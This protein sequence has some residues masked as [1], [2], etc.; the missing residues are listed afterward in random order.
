MPYVHAGY[1][2]PLI[3]A[4]YREGESGDRICDLVATTVAIAFAVPLAELRATTRRSRTVALARQ[5]AMY[6]AHVVFG[7]TLTDVARA[8]NRDRTTAAYACE[9]TENRRDDPAFDTVLDALEQV[10][11]LFERSLKFA[12]KREALV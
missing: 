6:L 9:M 10:C 12:S 8:F 1:Q 11:E 4:R 3:Y 2:A 7:L 5:S